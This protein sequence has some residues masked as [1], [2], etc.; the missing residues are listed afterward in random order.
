[1]SRSAFAC[2][3]LFGVL[4]CRPAAAATI[5]RPLDELRA[6]FKLG[7]APVPPEIFRDLGDGDLADSGPIR[8]TI[9]VKAAVGSNL[10]G[11]PI[12]S[13]NGWVTQVRAADK[14]GLTEET[15]YLF[16]GST[17]NKLLVAVARFNGGGSGIF[18][19]LHI[20]DAAVGR[21]VDPDGKVYDRINVT[22]VRSLPL[23]D[24]WDGKV[25]I[26]GN[27]VTIVTTGGVPGGDIVKPTSRTV[28]AV[29]P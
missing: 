18:T 17:A 25:T 21:G 4:C 15:A 6:G 27:T 3:A 2:A 13:S 10:Y 7:G 26:A 9:D 19:T 24:R 12:A 8:V 16:V 14:G 22:D 29:R 28:E 20:L 1:M 11:D 5:A 23:G